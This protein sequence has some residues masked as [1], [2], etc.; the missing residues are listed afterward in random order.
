[1]YLYGGE[2]KDEILNDLWQFNFDKHEWTQ[3]RSFQPRSGHSMVVADKSLIVFGGRGQYNEPVLVYNTG[4]FFLFGCFFFLSE[5]ERKTWKMVEIEIAHPKRYFH[6][7]NVYKDSM[8]ILG[9]IDNE[10][11][12]FQDFVSIKLDDMLKF[13]QTEI[14]GPDCLTHLPTGPFKYLLTYLDGK[15]IGRLCC[16]SNQINKHMYITSVILY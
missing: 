13:K 2:N 9:G 5:K 6:T 10:G 15:S 1:M 4:A 3:L 11:N 16:V 8:Y 12:V 7:A 14:T